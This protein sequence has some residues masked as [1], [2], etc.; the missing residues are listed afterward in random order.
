MPMVKEFRQLE[1]IIRG[2]SNHRRIQ[3]LEL[4]HTAPELDVAQI[5]RRLGINYKTASEHTR[6]L[7]ISGMITKH[8]KGASVQHDLT[9]RGRK[10]L[11]FLRTLE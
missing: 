8:N 6:R 9:S 11:I 7:A 3:I 4:L 5:S 1:R 2:V 10:T